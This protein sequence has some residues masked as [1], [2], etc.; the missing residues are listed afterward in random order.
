MQVE[1][2]SLMLGQQGAVPVEKRQKPAPRLESVKAHAL[3][4]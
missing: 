4:A 2:L 1:H 3:T